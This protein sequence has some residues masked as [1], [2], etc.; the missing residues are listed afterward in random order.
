MLNRGLEWLVF[1]LVIVLLY[2]VGKGLILFFKPLGH[3]FK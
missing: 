2:I 3:F 1:S